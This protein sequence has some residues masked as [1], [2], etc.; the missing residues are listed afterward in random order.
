MIAIDTNILVRFLTRDDKLQHA[1]A[2]K[3]FRVESV[4]IPETVLLE[5][6]WVL[7]FT[8][9]YSPNSVTSSFRKLLGLPN[10]STTDPELIAKALAWHETGLDFADALH[11]AA[12]RHCDR[13]ATFDKAFI[14]KAKG[15]AKC[16][17][18]MP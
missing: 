16:R 2:E 9:G 13:F 17:V 14:K 3:I 1:K 15:L 18:E 7:R 10:V 12:S 8:Y 6:E 4:F 11:L 5:T